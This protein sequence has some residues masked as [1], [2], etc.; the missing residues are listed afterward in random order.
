MD[1]AVAGGQRARK[2]RRLIAMAAGGAALLAAFAFYRPGAPVPEVEAAALWTGVVERGEFVRE[3]RG[4]GRLVVPPEELRWL[5]AEAGGRVE[6]RHVL[7]G[8]PVAADTILLELSNPD[9]ERQLAEAEAALRQEEADLRALRNEVRSALLEQ[10]SAAG[11]VAA[12]NAR[13]RLQAEADAALKEAGLVGELVERRSAVRFD[14]TATRHR[15]EQERLAILDEAS[16]ARI[17]SQEAAVARR[18]AV[19]ELRRRRRDGLR[20]RAGAAGILLDLPVEEGQQVVPGANLA[21]VADPARLAAVIQIPQTQAPDLAP[22]QAALVDTRNGVVPGVVERVDPAVRDGSV[23]VDVRLTGTPPRGARPDLSVDGTIRIETVPDALHVGRPAYG[24][25]E[26]AAGVFK[27]SPDGSTATRTPVR[28]GRGSVNRIE[29]LAGLAA[30]D[31]IILSDT[32]L[33]DDSATLRI[34]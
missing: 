27:L 16:A 17:R 10:E 3:V 22:G 15:L 1:F 4:P 24:Q 21:R 19:A 5:T 20:V 34:R 32:S 28:F 26:S 8:T 33:W 31:R 29:V 6:V 23:A 14:E 7:P 2:R 30:G 13:A 9:V 18:R 12:E 25:P 11:Q